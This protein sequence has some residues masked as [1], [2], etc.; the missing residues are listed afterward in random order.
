MKKSLAMTAVCAMLALTAS[1]QRASLGGDYVPRQR[2]GAQEERPS[3]QVGLRFGMNVSNMRFSYNDVE[4]EKQD[5][6]VG[7]HIGLIVDVPVYKNYLYIQPGIYFTQKGFK[8]DYYSGS[9][10]HKAKPMYM[11]FPIL[12]SGRYNVSR[13]VQLQ[14]SIGPYFAAGL[15]GKYTYTEKG[16][17]G[18]KTY[19]AKIFGSSDHP[20]YSEEENGLGCKRFDAGLSV[21]AGILVNRHFFVGFQYDLGMVNMQP[22]IPQDWEWGIS[23]GETKNRNFMLGIGCNF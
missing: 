3:V 19:S 10:E 22:S 21:G 23:I 17:Y 5:K 2:G 15:C 4:S 7:Y 18:D 1:A 14:V 11:E 16:Y 9:Y 12:I 8:M 13:K 20:W 6:L